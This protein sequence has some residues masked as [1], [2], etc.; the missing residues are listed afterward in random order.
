MKTPKAA[1]LPR[2]WIGKPHKEKVVRD[3]SDTVLGGRVISPGT[4]NWLRT[5]LLSHGWDKDNIDTVVMGTWSASRRLAD[6]HSELHAVEPS[7]LQKVAEQL[8]EWS[9]KIIGKGTSESA[10]VTTGWKHLASHPSWLLAKRRGV[11]V[12]GTTS[13]LLQRTTIS[14]IKDLWVTLGEKPEHRM[15]AIRRV[16]L[17]SW[18][19]A[20]ALKRYEEQ[21][22]NFDL[23]VVY[24]GV[25]TEDVIHHE[26]GYLEAMRNATNG[27][28]IYE[29]LSSSPL[30]VI[31]S[32]LHRI[33]FESFLLGRTHG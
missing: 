27:L 2:A 8:K 22:S 14:L 32:S 33:G 9:P 23:T 19:S 26:L 20:D 12:I 18:S 5:T 21:A 29:M 24:G 6:L 28:I 30:K 10:F 16:N 3:D 25:G 4:K 11:A 7:D 31:S 17:L 1:P 15:P 13:D